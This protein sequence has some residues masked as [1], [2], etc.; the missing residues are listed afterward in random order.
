MTL[1][2]MVLQYLPLLV[3]LHPKNF[4]WYILFCVFLIHYTVFSNSV[5]LKQNVH[6]FFPRGIS[7]ETSP[8][9]SQVAY[10]LVKVLAAGRSTQKEL[11]RNFCRKWAT[12]QAKAW[13]RMLK[14]DIM[15]EEMLR[16][17]VVLCLLLEQQNRVFVFC[18]TP[19]LL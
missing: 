8:R 18:L 10:N 1:M 6:L 5:F 12:N 14:V 19:I 17:L 16:C 4:K 7:G 11:D 3:A 13:A 15:E 9:G 2:V